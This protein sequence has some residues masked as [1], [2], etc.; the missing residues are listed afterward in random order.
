MRKRRFSILLV[1]ED[2]SE[3]KHLRATSSHVRIALLVFSLLV[4]A[5]VF[6]TIQYVS[7]ARDAAALAR[8]SKENSY[9]QDQLVALEN[10]VSQ[11]QVQMADLVEREKVLRTMSGLA[12]IDADVRKVGVGGHGF[13]EFHSQSDSPKE[14]VG[15]LSLVTADLDQLLRQVKLEKKSFQDVEIAFQNNLEKLE[16]TP[17]IWPVTGYVSRG[18]GPCIDPFTGQRRLHEGIDVV[19][20]VGTPIKAT[21]AGI[22]AERGWR[23]GYGWVVVVDHGYGYQTTYG[24]LNAIEVRKGERVKRGQVIATLGNSGR[25]TGPHLHYEVRVNGQPVDPLRFILSDVVVD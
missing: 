18:F 11:F 2:N 1:P 13:E 9:L 20:R 16:H 4:I 17:T 24:H 5:T 21:A 22:V 10:R 19:N 25:S 15:S 23:N 14:P 3:V 12:E 6:L 8:L 7:R